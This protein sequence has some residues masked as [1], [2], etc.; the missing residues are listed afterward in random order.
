M[1][2][3]KR[4]KPMCFRDG[5]WRTVKFYGVYTL[6]KISLASSAADGWVNALLINSNFGG[7]Y[8][9]DIEFYLRNRSGS[10]CQLSGSKQCFSIFQNLRRYFYFLCILN[11]AEKMQICLNISY[12]IFSRFLIELSKYLTS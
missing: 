12:L 10:K 4:V 5:K 7:V 11:Y 9:F 2:N 8:L 1:G 3:I 6:L